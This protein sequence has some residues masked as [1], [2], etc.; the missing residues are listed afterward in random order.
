MFLCKVSKLI[1]HTTLNTIQGD[2]NELDLEFDQDKKCK[3]PVSFKLLRSRPSRYGIDL[4]S[5]KL[6]K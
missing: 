2:S 3:S 1:W 4:S 6:I 5:V